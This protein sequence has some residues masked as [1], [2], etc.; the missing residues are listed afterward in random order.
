[1]WSCGVIMYLLIAGVPPFNGRYREDIILAIKNAK[2]QYSG[3][4]KIYGMI[5]FAWARVSPEA[6]DLI[7]LLLTKDPKRRISAKNAMKHKWFEKFPK[8][9]LKKTMPEENLVHS[10]RNLKN[11]KAQCTLQKA[12]LT[13]IASQ[14]LDPRKELQMR[15]MFSIMDTDKNGEVTKDELVEGYS[16]IY[17][18]RALAKKNS[19]EV[20]KKADINNNGVIDYTEFVMANVCQDWKTLNE[21]TLLQAFNFYDEDKNGYI[22]IEELR[23]VFGTICSEEEIQEMIKEVDSNGDNKIS[24]IEFKDM[25]SCV[26]LSSTGLREAWSLSQYYMDQLIVIDER[27][28]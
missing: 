16:K 5:G 15:E 9:Q 23:K 19:V 24:F 27:V 25:M 10:L 1:M 12:V 20:L 6:K 21:K 2:M 3:I 7:S 17:K 28:F 8:H 22:S 14:L 4:S 18:N 13:Y 11:F 26:K